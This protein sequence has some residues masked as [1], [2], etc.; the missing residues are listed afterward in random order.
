MTDPLSVIWPLLD[1]PGAVVTAD[2]AASWPAELQAELTATGM[3]RQSSGAERVLCPECRNHIEE[4]VTVSRPGAQLQFVI[5]C[6]ENLRVVLSP[7]DLRQ[8][9][10]DSSHL[11]AMIA[12]AL[13]LTG[14]LA[15][16]ANGRVWRLGRWKYQGETRDMLLA[17][18]L[19]QADADQVRRKMTEAK[20]P[21]VLVPLDAPARDF[22][23]G[24]PPPIIRLSE[25]VSLTNGVMGLKPGEILD[26]VHDTNER[27]E[28]LQDALFDFV[29]Q[30]V[31]RAMDTKLT[32]EMLL[33]TYLANNSSAREAAKV[34]NTQGFRISH[35]QI[36]RRL[37]RFKDLVRTDS[38][39]SVVRTRSSQRRDTPQKKQE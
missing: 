21:I 11:A 22:W 7:N 5:A 14:K 26:L 20:R 8:W 6:P 34:L 16:L 13:Q 27:E 2:V 33:Q 39:D 28:E 23:K 32:D 18:G 38:S 4:V 19:R 25:V 17:L 31:H 35:S 37:A 24:Q 29:E 10:V 30:K 15:E 9:I 1:L 36:S 3:L 12:S